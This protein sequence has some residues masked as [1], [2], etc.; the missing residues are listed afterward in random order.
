MQLFSGKKHKTKKELVEQIIL[1]NYN[2]Y[3]RLSYGYTRNEMDAND[4]VQNGAYRAIKSSQALKEPEYA[5]TWVYRIMLNECFSFKRQRSFVSYEKMLDEN[6]M[7]RKSVEDTYQNIDLMNALDSLSGQ[8]KAVIILKYFE[9]KTLE[10]IAAVLDE[11]LN[12]VKSRLY[13]SLK[14]LR[15]VLADEVSP[16]MCDE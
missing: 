3:Y 5:S 8:E 14:K 10:E 16:N 11:N 9:D 13:R 6:G 2:Q 1:E 15:S 7:E 4:I 12:T